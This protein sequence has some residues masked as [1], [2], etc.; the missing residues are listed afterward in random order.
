MV[1]CFCNTW[2]E[3]VFIEFWLFLVPSFLL[4][5]FSHCLFLITITVLALYSCPFPYLFCSIH[6]IF[7]PIVITEACHRTRI[8]FPVFFP[9]LYFTSTCNYYC[10]IPRVTEENAISLCF[11]YQ[12]SPL[13]GNIRT[14]RKHLDWH[15]D[16]YKLPVSF[17][18]DTF[19]QKSKNSSFPLIQLFKK[20]YKKN[21]NWCPST[22]C[23]I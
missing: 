21:R 17:G 12:H 1:R 10:L 9:Q 2:E 22:T 20:I 14:W 15:F 11:Q 4:T 23:F 5:L 3:I 7:W 8:T 18:N 16:Q 19:F 6:V 13:E